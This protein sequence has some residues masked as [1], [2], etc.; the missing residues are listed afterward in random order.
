MSELR[1]RWVLLRNPH[2]DIRFEGPVTIGRGFSLHMPGGGTFIVGSGVEFGRR[3]RSEVGGKGR[4]AIGAGTRIGHAVIISC[5]TSIAIGERCELGN[6][7]YI[8]DGSHR[9]R[10][11]TKPFLQQGY[12]YRDIT[13]GDGARIERGCTLVNSVGSRAVVG[14]GSVVSREVPPRSDAIGVP[15]EVTGY[16]GSDGEDPARLSPS[17]TSSG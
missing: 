10:D 15:A 14:P 11:L 9:Y 16:R 6:D 1:R 7:T 13:I 12:N 5:D 8:A 3:F 2:A 17:S 4:I